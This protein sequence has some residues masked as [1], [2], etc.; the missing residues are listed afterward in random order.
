MIPEHEQVNNKK[1]ESNG[2]FLSTLK[3]MKNQFSGRGCKGANLSVPVLCMGKIPNTI[4]SVARLYGLHF[5]KEIDLTSRR[6][7]YAGCNRL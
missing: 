6:T 1:E 3:A 5:S 4:H 7:L 2:K